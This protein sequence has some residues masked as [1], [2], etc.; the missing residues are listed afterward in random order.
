MKILLWEIASIPIVGKPKC[1]ILPDIVD[2]AF[3]LVSLML[4]VR[5]E[6]H[7]IFIIS[8]I[9]QTSTMNQELRIQYC[10]VINIPVFE[11]A[12]DLELI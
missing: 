12:S 9:T 6:E 4:P 7:H 11:L 3:A 8:S 10:S 1:L 2:S 5:C